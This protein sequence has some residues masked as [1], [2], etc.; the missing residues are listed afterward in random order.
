[1]CIC[2]HTS[3]AEVNI[4]TYPEWRNSGLFFSSCR[5]IQFG[6]FRAEI[7]KIVV[8]CAEILVRYFYMLHGHHD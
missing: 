6:V 5:N 1:M 7:F 8:Y 3:Y 2:T 4:S